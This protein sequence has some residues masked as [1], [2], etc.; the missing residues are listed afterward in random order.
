MGGHGNRRGRGGA[1][2][3]RRQRGRTGGLAAAV[4]GPRRRSPARENHGPGGHT[5][6]SATARRRG[7][8]S[9]PPPPAGATRSNRPGSLGSDTVPG[10]DRGSSAQG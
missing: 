9:V 10:R 8:C 6:V 2:G 4:G 7:W 3:A 5:L 1:H